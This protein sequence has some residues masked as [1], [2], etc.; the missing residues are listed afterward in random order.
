[1]WDTM[2][3]YSGGAWSLFSL[4][5]VL[6]CVE[7]EGTA[8]NADKD[9]MKL[10]ISVLAGS[11]RQTIKLYSQQTIECVSGQLVYVRYND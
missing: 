4:E 3:N 10:N 8:T 7:A 5:Q 11:G 1:M 6:L 2:N 9:S